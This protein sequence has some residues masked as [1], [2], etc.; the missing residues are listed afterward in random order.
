MFLLSPA[1]PCVPSR[2]LCPM[3]LW[4]AVRKAASSPT[5]H[6]KGLL[7]SLPGLP[8]CPALPQGRQGPGRSRDSGLH[9]WHMAAIPNHTASEPHGPQ[10]SWWSRQRGTLEPE[11]P[12][13]LLGPGLLLRQVLAFSL[14]RL[15]H[16]EK[17]EGFLWVHWESW[18]SACPEQVSP[19]PST[20]CCGLAALRGLVGPLSRGCG[21][22][23]WSPE[24]RECRHLFLVWSPRGS[25]LLAWFSAKAAPTM[26]MGRNMCAE[27]SRV[28]EWVT[29]PP[30]CG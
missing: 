10:R 22:G 27:V 12:D 24:P 7:F 9:A 17:A 14:P 30:Q 28:Q 15:P 8:L 23:P 20:P 21:L 26:V 1:S 19:V 13:L 6:P 18:L 2:P 25:H 16:R 11:R 4:E 29:P 5:P 3:N